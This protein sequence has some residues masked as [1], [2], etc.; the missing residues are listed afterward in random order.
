M[1]QKKLQRFEDLKTFPNVLEYPKNMAGKWNEF[2][3]N[4]HPITLELACGKGEYAL[5]LGQLYPQKNFIGID[6]KGNRIWVGAKKALQ[7]E[8]SNVAFLRTQID[9]VAEYFAKDEVTEIWITFPDPQLRKSKAKKRLTHPKFLRLYQQFIIPGGLIHLK[10]DSPELYDFTRLVIAVYGCV[11]HND[12]ADTYN[13]QNI[14]EELR[15]K[16]HYE[17]LD[18][19]GSSRIHYLCFS[20]PPLLAGK[21]K[22]TGLKQLLKDEGGD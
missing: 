22:D 4:D 13:Q 1:A 5:G 10:T 11:L 8:L 7:N 19:A 2:F 12:Y 17:M 21:E 14:K 15:I 9:Q 18:I 3:K 16:T 20:L 6:Q